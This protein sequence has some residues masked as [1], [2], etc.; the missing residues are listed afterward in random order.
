MIHKLES[1]RLLLLQQLGRLC[2]YTDSVWF[3]PYRFL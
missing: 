3:L 2:V 1:D